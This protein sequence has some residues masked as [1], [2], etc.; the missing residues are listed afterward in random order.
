MVLGC[1]RKRFSSDLRI[2]E[3]VV[4]L[5]EEREAVRHPHRSRISDNRA[6]KKLSHAEQRVAI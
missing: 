1:W 6:T 3:N 2:R 4:R 5:T